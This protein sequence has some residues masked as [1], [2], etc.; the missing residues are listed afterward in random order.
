MCK[1]SAEINE[2]TFEKAW[3][4]SMYLAGKV[5]ELSFFNLSV[6]LSAVQNISIASCYFLVLAIIVSYAANT[7]TH[8]YRHVHP[9]DEFSL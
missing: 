6:C 9:C 7:H 4:T 8:T 2:T 5:R 3:W 1:N